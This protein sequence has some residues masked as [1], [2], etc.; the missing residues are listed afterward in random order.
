M[1]IK[2]WDKR[3][4]IKL[5]STTVVNT[6]VVLK[7]DLSIKI[8]KDRY[9]IYTVEI[10]PFDLTNYEFHPPYGIGDSLR[11]AFLNLRLSMRSKRK[12]FKRSFHVWKILE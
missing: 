1:G 10:A 9:G 6:F 2:I 3:L 4:T 12:R 8:T 5:P 7:K 11:E